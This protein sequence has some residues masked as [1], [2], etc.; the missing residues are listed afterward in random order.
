MGSVGM[1]AGALGDLDWWAGVTPLA[2]RDHSLR[3]YGGAWRGSLDTCRMHG[4]RA[5]MNQERPE[6]VRV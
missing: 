3:M 4:A 5:A 6:C 2:R 1:P